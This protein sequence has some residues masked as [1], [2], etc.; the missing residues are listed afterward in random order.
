MVQISL[1]NS[2][3]AKQISIFT[4]VALAVSCLAAHRPK[5]PLRRARALQPF[6]G[7]SK[8]A[9]SALQ[10]CFG[11]SMARFIR[12]CTSLSGPPRNSKAGYAVPAVPI[13]SDAMG[14]LEQRPF[15]LGRYH[16]PGAVWDFPS[17]RGPKVGKPDPRTVN[18]SPALVRGFTVGRMEWSELVESRHHFRRG[19]KS[20]PEDALRK[21]ESIYSPEAIAIYH[22]AYLTKSRAFP[23]MVPAMM[24]GLRR[25]NS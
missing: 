20:A 23:A 15:V 12:S 5:A 13:A 10:N 22:I 2:A 6:G 24:R 18:S 19:V 3:Q 1:L 8:A 11:R 17:I 25:R 9:Q 14:G 16:V 21:C 4:C 7:V